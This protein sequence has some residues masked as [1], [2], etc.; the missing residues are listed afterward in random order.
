MCRDA[1]SKQQVINNSRLLLPPERAA[2]SAGPGKGAGASAEQPSSPGWLSG[3]PPVPDATQPLPP[4]NNP[5]IE[6]ALL[7]ELPF[8]PLLQ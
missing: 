1:Q 4:E 5:G 7:S 8:P 6:T 2:A 3:P